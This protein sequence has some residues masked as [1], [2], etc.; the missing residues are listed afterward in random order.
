MDVSNAFLAGMISLKKHEPGIPLPEP[1]VKV[2]LEATRPK[3]GGPFMENRYDPQYPNE[4]P[5]PPRNGRKGPNFAAWLLVTLIVGGLAGGGMAY[6]ITGRQ[7][8]QYG[9][10]RTPAVVNLQTVATQTDATAADLT[11]V[12]RV[13]QSASP[14]VVEV[15][16]ES[17]VT[18]P[19]WGSF[20]TSGAGSGVIV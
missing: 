16:T 1:S 17:K 15:T 7:M 2:R 8:A 14:S 19:F 10:S 11:A 6:I 5:Q 20:V 18:H 13:A 12:A 3:N 9:L 4:N